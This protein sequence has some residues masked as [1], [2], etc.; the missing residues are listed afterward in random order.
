[1]SPSKAPLSAGLAAAGAVRAMLPMG[2]GGG[3]GGPPAPPIIMG[4]GGGGPGM[5]L[6]SGREA[7]CD[8]GPLL[9]LAKQL[10]D[11]FVWGVSLTLRR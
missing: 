11:R 8:L 2:G 7:V 3:G 5:C 6:Y 4:G 1:M 9:W 10:V